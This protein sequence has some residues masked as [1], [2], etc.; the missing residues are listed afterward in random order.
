MSICLYLLHNVCKAFVKLL[1]ARYIQL[2]KNERELT[3]IVAGFKESW[4]FPCSG[5][6]DG[7]HI[8]VSVLSELDIDYYNRKGWY[9]VVL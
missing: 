9:S 8:P 1:M 4:C 5:A 3:D 7:T 6:I 2:P